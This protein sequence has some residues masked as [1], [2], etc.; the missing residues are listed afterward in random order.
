MFILS[1]Y[2]S[3]ILSDN[4]KGKEEKLMVCSVDFGRDTVY[5]TL[6]TKERIVFM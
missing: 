3:H 4:A 5:Q 1:S 2:L 6:F